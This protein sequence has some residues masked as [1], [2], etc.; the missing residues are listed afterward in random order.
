MAGITIAAAQYPLDRLDSFAAFEAKLARW[1]A[2]AATEGAELLVFPEY[3]ALELAG[4]F[5]VAVET[6]IQA[7]IDAVTEILPKVDIV[8]Q[9][10]AERHEVHILAGSA[11]VR[12]AGHTPNTARLFAPNGR[13]GVQDKRMMTRGERED[14]RVT[15]GGPVRVF[16][17]ALG[18]IGIAICY[19][20]EFPLIAR[21]Q[22]EAGA[23]VILAPSLTE[24][25][26]GYNRVRIGAMARALEN[27]CVTVQAPLVG[28]ATW[29]P[30]G[31]GRG[32]AALYGPPDLGFPEDGIIAIGEMDRPQWVF[33]RA[34][35][36]AVAR[37]RREGTVLNEAHWPEQ[38]LG[39][40]EPAERI[41]LS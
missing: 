11:A 18:G 14:W 1:V 20:V 2:E 27:Q 7:T 25:A 19:D 21:A 3:A 5:G 13:V 10:L 24:T 31:Q 33:G 41:A 29:S 23:T 35:L 32:R 28:P 8:H 17:T 37:V 30:V 15:R 9:E 6:D 26:A 36:D 38:E 40:L 16:E 12:R 4:L 34:D 39:P 22:V